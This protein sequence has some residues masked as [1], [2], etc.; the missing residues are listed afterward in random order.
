MSDAPPT[1]EF[2]GRCIRV[3]GARVGGLHAFMRAT[4]FPRLA[5]GLG[6]GSS[7]KAGGSKVDAEL[8]AAVA[9]GAPVGRACV[10]TRRIWAAV[11][12]AGYTWVDTQVGVATP[13]DAPTAVAT[14]VD[15]VL[16]DAEGRVVLA[17]IKTGG[18]CVAAQARQ[19]PPPVDHLR[20]VVPSVAHVQ[21]AATAAMY[22]ATTGTRPVGAI[23]VRYVRRKGGG[24]ALVEACKAPAKKGGDVV[25][26]GCAILGMHV[27][28]RGGGSRPAKR[29]C[30]RDGGGSTGLTA[31]LVRK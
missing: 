16:H 31:W 27:P 7:S 29:V 28:A 13:K 11:T 24:V 3:D 30:T 22:E 5:H 2:D 10:A 21:V 19:C 4:Y 14:F 20:Q 17:E 8:A 18:D 9:A 23:V 15:A 1:V 25:D 6:G 12:D 26:A